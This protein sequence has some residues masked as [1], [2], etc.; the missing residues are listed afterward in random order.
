MYSIPQKN[1]VILYNDHFREP[2]TLTPIAEQLAMELSLPIST[3]RVCHNWD[4]NNQPS[5][6]QAK[7][8]THCATARLN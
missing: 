2:V 8:L 3:T 6:C 1:Q 4:L 5:A 7:A